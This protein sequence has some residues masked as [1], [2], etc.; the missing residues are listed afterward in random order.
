MKFSLTHTYFLREFS[1][2]IFKFEISMAFTLDK[3]LLKLL[4]SVANPQFSKRDEKDPPLKFS[5]LFHITNEIDY[6]KFQ[7][8]HIL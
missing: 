1:P 2:I 4:S 8:I 6:G 5:E 7:N 3:L